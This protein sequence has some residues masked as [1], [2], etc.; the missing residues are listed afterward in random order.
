MFN[1][2]QAEP[3]VCT[4]IQRPRSSRGQ[5]ADQPRDMNRS[6]PQTRR[7]RER[8][9]AGD[10]SQTRLIHVP[11]Q[12]ANTAG[13]RKQTRER[14]AHSRDQATVSTGRDQAAVASTDCP[15][16][17]RSLAV[18][19]TAISPL[20]NIGREPRLA[21]HFPS[22]RIVVSIFPLVSFPV[23]IRIIPAYDLI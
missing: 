3:L 1:T 6:R 5:Y 9:Q 11:E 18:A 2:G 7:F 12:S 19:T 21:E 23:R 10:R 16:T 22:R 14:S 13:L 17:V 20:T 15:Q 8:E 4:R